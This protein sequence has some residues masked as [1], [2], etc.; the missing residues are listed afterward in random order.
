MVSRFMK[1]PCK[2]HLLAAKRILR[3]MKG[4]LECGILFLAA[5][6]NSEIEIVGYTVADWSGDVGDRK[7]TFGYM[8][9]LGNAPISWCSKKQEVVYLVGNLAK[10][11]GKYFPI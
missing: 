11:I 1:K 8:F 10:I 2:D 7:S 6:E 3:Y 5:K 9:M 4:T